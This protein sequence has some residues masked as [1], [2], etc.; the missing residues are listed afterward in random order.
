[1]IWNCYPLD[2]LTVQQSAMDYVSNFFG[3]VDSY[4]NADI[5]QM[6]NRTYQCKSYLSM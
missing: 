3:V 6:I 1:M 5:N 2:V 4:L